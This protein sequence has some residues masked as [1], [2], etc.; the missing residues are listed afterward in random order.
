M[1]RWRIAATDRRLG[2]D[3]HGLPY[4]AHMLTGEEIG[5]DELV[6]GRDWQQDVVARV[7]RAW[8]ARHA[9]AALGHRSTAA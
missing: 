2:L 3:C 4:S 7:K 5:A 9:A 8:E 6:E 1:R